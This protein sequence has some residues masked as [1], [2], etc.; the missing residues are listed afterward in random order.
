MVEWYLI[1]PRSGKAGSVII[2]VEGRDDARCL[3]VALLE[4]SAPD[5]RV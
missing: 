1:D 2:E 3:K 5:R 4:R